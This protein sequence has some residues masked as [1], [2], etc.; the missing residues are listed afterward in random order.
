MKS[1]S[2]E[3]A[4]S[5]NERQFIVQRKWRLE[6]SKPNF[7]W[8]NLIMARYFT[9]DLHFN[10]T[11]INKYANRPI[12]KALDAGIFLVDNANSVL[13]KEDLLIH[14]G[15]FCLT[16]PD[17][18]GTEEDI[19]IDLPPEHWM[20]QF[21]SRLIL[22]AG[23]H[24]D[25]HSF[26]A[27]AKSL[28][29]DLNQNYR[30]VTVGHYPST[31]QVIKKTWSG[32][33]VFTKHS[34]DGYQGQ[35]GTTQKPHIHLC[36]HVHDKWILNFD[37]ARNVLNVN[38]GVDVWGYKPVRDSEITELLDYFRATMWTKI[39]PSPGKWTNFALTRKALDE[40]KIAHSAEVKA[41]REARKAE[42]LLKKGLT[43]AECERR[44]IEAMKKK[45]LI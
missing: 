34:V 17:R 40:F 22:L 28:T 4:R 3:T 11:L 32:R 6:V 2:Q 24:D 44:R 23:N 26:E 35:N 19:P 43:P 37:A 27:D 15:D 30:N 20:S 5:S 42:K 9:S 13:K 25:G 39:S 21:N 38:V 12:K 31:S 18:H 36:G 7:F 33:T 14:A 29:L 10:S 41:Q 45:G 1:S 16:S 8:Y